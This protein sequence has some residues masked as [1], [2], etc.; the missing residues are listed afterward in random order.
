[1]TASPDEA[2][3]WQCPYCDAIRPTL[4][5]I[6]Q[7]ITDTTSGQHEGVSG[8][9]PDQDLVAVDADGDV[10]EVVEATDVVRPQDASLQGVSK[11][12]QIVAAWVANDQEADREAITAV[13]DA[14]RDYTTQILGQIRRGE[15]SRD[16]WVDLDQQLLKAMQNRL[17]EY[18]Q[19][20]QSEGETMS[21]QQQ[22]SELESVEKSLDGASGKQVIL[23]AY[24]MAASDASM[25]GIADAIGE[26]KDISYE[27]VRR[28]IND[29]KE[30]EISQ[31]EV[32][33]A[34]DDEIQQVIEPVLADHGLLE[35]GRQRDQE[36]EPE[37]EPE[38][39]PE[40]VQESDS[41]Q[42]S[43]SVASVAAEG[44]TMTVSTEEVV[45]SVRMMELLEREAAHEDDKGK[46]FVASEARRRFEE[47]LQG[48]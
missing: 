37:S 46:E 15:I 10:I 20:S 11:R 38:P 28:T 21:T 7:H 2:I 47:L 5:E 36:S 19:Q 33:A 44:G 26:I 32:D 14:D 41:V 27:H 48:Q 9:S 35:E 40:P 29:I 1:M 18:D 16:Y 31:D 23:N 17:S 39:E 4:R 8:E 13:T 43:T 3:E 34:Q 45:E 24:P 42:E 22:Q 30:G 6:Q 12:R 25:A